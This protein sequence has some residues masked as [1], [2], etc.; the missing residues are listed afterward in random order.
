M[1][2]DEAEDTREHSAPTVPAR[3]EGRD[4][5]VLDAYSRAVIAVVDKVGPAVVSIAR[6]RGDGVQGG[7]G[8]G[9][10]LAPDG[11]VLT[12]S[13]VVHGAKDLEVR[14]TDGRSLPA[15]LVGEDPATDL[16]VVRVGASDLPHIAPGGEKKDRLRV[17]QLVIAI[18]NPLGFQS[19]VSAGVVSALGRSLR[20][21]D[22]RLI[23]N[24]VQHTAPLN[25]GNSGGPLVDSHGRLVGINTAMIAYAQGLFFAVPASTVTW[26]VPKLMSDGV[27][28]RGYLGLAGRQRPIDR[29]LAR[30]HVLTQPSG[31]EVMHLQ[32]G[33]PAATA[34]VRDGDIVL[35][36]DGDTV[37]NVDDLHRALTR[38]T[39]TREVTL[40][41]LRRT[42]RIT[43][44]VLPRPS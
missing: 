16:A 8:S 27:V 1:S 9:V 10:V 26:V 17:G 24:I 18:G 21:R 23:E 12:N 42:E 41:I 30:V 3:D 11:Y 38:W 43:V 20:A 39:A 29:R 36:I 13:H 15:R 31:V 37:T 19:T 2:Y 40:S 5:E 7:E 4:E 34:G 6:G 25:P 14:F 44:R 32:P 28:R 33:S 35:A 22:G